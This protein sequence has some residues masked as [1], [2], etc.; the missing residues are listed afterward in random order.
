MSHTAKLKQERPDLY[1]D[2]SIRLFAEKAD[3]LHDLKALCDTPGGQILVE[4]LN[5]EIQNKVSKLAYQHQELTHQQMVAIA[6]GIGAC[7]DI[8]QVLTTSGEALKHNQE[9]M[10]EAMEE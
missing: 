4:V 6:A 9:Q 2:E 1:E 8:V 5:N 3:K 7:K 10:K